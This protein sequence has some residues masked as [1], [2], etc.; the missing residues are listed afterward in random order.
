MPERS[1][2]VYLDD[3]VVRTVNEIDRKPHRMGLVAAHRRNLDI[4]ESVF[5][6]A[7]RRGR[8]GSPVL[9]PGR[10]VLVVVEPHLDTAGMILEADV[11]H[12][13]AIAAVRARGNV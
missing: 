9:A 13:R 11:A 5:R 8:Q 2:H 3:V 6:T 7:P 1:V 12:A 4:R 10:V